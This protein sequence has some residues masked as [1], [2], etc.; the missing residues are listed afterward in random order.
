M[1]PPPAAAMQP[2][3]N[4]KRAA[5]WAARRFITKERG[6]F[7]AEKIRS[8]QLGHFDHPRKR[9][10]LIAAHWALIL[11]TQ[12]SCCDP[13]SIHLFSDLNQLLLFGS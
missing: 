9:L 4:E 13:Q 7:V 11:R 1:A 10:P 12:Q 3:A 2:E 5:L 6:R 8:L